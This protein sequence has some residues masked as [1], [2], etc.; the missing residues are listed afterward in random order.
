VAVSWYTAAQDTPRTLIA[1]SGDSGSTFGN[2]VT[3]STGR[4]QGYTSVAVDESGG[5]VVSWIEQGGEAS[6]LLIREVDAK[7]VAGPVLQVATG[8]R[9]NLGY[10]RLVRVGKDTLIAWGSASSKV[11]TA[12]LHK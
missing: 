3:V 6:R 9:M 2:A 10:P 11:M 8:S 12:V 4:S 1:L 5:A 7:G